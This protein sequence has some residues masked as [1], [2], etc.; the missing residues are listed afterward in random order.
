[1]RRNIGFSDSL[2][3]HR[4]RVGV[5]CGR[6]AA[7][8]GPCPNQLLLGWR[9]RDVGQRRIMVHHV[10]RGPELNWVNSNQS[11]A[12]FGYTGSGGGT[13]FGSVPPPALVMSSPIVANSLVF[14]VAPASNPTLPNTY[15]VGVL[16]GGSHHHRQRVES[17]T[18]HLRLR[19]KPSEW[20]D[21]GHLSR[22]RCRG[23][24]PGLATQRHRR[25][26]Q[27]SR[28]QHHGDLH[29]RLLDDWQQQHLQPS[30]I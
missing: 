27:P 17:G 13:A 2:R 20:D 26:D 8:G 29:H 15:Q 21:V 3:L 11:I 22:R 1:M 4:V 6:F 23:R 12:N 28:R 25:P 9:F 24:Q 5:H 16:A 19:G 7:D 14:G 30:E 10:G 18:G